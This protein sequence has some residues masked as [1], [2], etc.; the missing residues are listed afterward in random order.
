M[1]MMH[2]CALV[3]L[4]THP[5]FLNA[6]Y[7]DNRVIQRRR[8]IGTAV[9]GLV[10]AS[11]GVWAA[12]K[13]Y[14]AFSKGGDTGKK[15][16][17][18]GSGAR[19]ASQG[20]NPG[21]PILPDPAHTLKQAQVFFKNETAILVEMAADGSEIVLK[22]VKDLAY[23]GRLF[24]LHD[25]FALLDRKNFDNDLLIFDLPYK[26]GVDSLT[27]YLA[28]LGDTYPDITRSINTIIIATGDIHNSTLHDMPA[29]VPRDHFDEKVKVM[30][31][32]YTDAQHSFNTAADSI[33]GKRKLLIFIKS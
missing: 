10:I 29:R 16:D 8:R 2:V 1:K 20:I 19:G 32:S 7:N 11:V 27:E 23:G 24:R 25:S 5:A 28:L 17:G 15:G 33:P 30:V 31:C 21:T 18:E 14:E 22:T 12:I 26:G 3:A 6:E 4:I 9:A 13:I